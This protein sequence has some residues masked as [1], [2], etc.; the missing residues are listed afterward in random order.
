MYDI[1]ICVIRWILINGKCQHNQF[2]AFVLRL[3]N[4]RFCFQ[5]SGYAKTEEIRQLSEVIQRWQ[6]LS[7]HTTKRL[8]DAERTREFWDDSSSKLNVC[9]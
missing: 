1:E 7:D 4:L 9:K 8:R 5:E 2:L 3:S 6:D